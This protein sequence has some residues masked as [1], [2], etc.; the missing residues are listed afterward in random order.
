VPQ[1]VSI[2]FRVPRRRWRIAFL[3]AFGVL[4]NFFDRINLAVSR[5][6]LNASFGMSLI[7]FGYLSSAYN[8]TYALM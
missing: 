1:P 6:A 8:W 5:E 7:A 4:V 3:L 2:N